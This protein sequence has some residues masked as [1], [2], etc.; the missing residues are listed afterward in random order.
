[1]LLHPPPHPPHA[2]EERR[3]EAV[4]QGLQQMADKMQQAVN[5]EGMREVEAVLAPLPPPQVGA[6]CPARCCTET[7]AATCCC[8]CRHVSYSAAVGRSPTSGQ[9]AVQCCGHDPLIL[10]LLFMSVVPSPCR[11]CRIRT[12]WT[13][14]P[15]I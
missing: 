9:G 7:A 8:A 13:W 11:S 10:M 2:E 1:M 15:A 14:M 5:L 6:R 4:I 3:C 12:M